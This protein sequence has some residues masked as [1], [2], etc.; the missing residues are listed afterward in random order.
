MSELF[1]TKY[2]EKWFI[3]EGTP[4][5]NED[6]RRLYHKI[7]D[8]ESVAISGIQGWAHS[9]GS[10]A[11]ASRYPFESHMRNMLI[12][13]KGADYV[14]NIE[15]RELRQKQ[16]SEVENMEA[17]RKHDEYLRDLESKFDD[18]LGG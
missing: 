17:R 7:K 8:W 14:H 10:A 6:R 15:A 12:E 3:S 11:R 16:K 9:M 13:V 2:G 1:R 5:N 18:I 4:L